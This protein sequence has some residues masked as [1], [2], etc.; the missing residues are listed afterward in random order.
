MALF[1]S[2][3]YFLKWVF[4]QCKGWCRRPFSKTGGNTPRTLYCN[5]TLMA[6]CYWSK[7]TY[8]VIRFVWVSAKFGTCTVVSII[9]THAEDKTRRFKGKCKHFSFFSFNECPMYTHDGASAKFS[10]NSHETDNIVGTFYL[11]SIIRNT[12]N[13]TEK[14]SIF[15]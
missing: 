12:H 1:A 13:G 14:S 6:E 9:G 10:T 11:L 15:S 7:E 2:L 5:T 4:L 3:N 8:T